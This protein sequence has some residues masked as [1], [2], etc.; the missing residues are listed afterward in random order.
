MTVY[1][2]EETQF[3][4]KARNRFKVK[5]WLKIPGRDF[6]VSSVVKTL[7]FNAG[8]ESSIPGWGAEIP[9]ALWPKHKTGTIL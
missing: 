7:P 6:P 1:C 5:G 8:G 9:P 2:P 3:K 4:F